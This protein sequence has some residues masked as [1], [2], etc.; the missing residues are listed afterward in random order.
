VNRLHQG[1]AEE[2]I[3]TREETIFALG[4]R[5]PE[6]IAVHGDVADRQWSLIMSALITLIYRE[7]CRARLAEMRKYVTAA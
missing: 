7:Y 6:I 5:Q 1:A 4:R 2:T 3:Q